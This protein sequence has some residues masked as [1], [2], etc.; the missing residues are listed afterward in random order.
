MYDPVP[1]VVVTTNDPSDP[2]LQVT[3][4]CDAKV[5]DASTFA[6]SITSTSELVVGPQDL[7]S[8]ISTL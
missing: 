7:L 6:G 1:P 3:L 5:S 4:V 8:V 2:P